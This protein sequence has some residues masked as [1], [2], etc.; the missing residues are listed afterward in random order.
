MCIRDRDKEIF[1]DYSNNFDEAGNAVSHFLGKDGWCSWGSV[2]FIPFKNNFIEMPDIKFVK[3]LIDGYDKSRSEAANYIDDVRNLIYIIKGYGNLSEDEIREKIRSRVLTV[4]YTHLN[5]LFLNLC[6]AFVSPVKRLNTNIAMF[7]MVN[8][9]LFKPT[10][11]CF[12]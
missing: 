4:S 3:S 8:T 12:L 10:I 1:V 7:L 5:F 6:G 9:G 2:P 11:Y